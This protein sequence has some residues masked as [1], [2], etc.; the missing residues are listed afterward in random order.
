M[1]ES[2]YAPLCTKFP[3]VS[4]IGAGNVGRTVAQRIVERNLADAYL[5]D[6]VEG[7]PQ[8]IALDLTEAK[9]LE[10]HNRQIVGSNDYKDTANS[11]VIVITAGFPRKPGMSRDDLLKINGKIVTEVAQKCCEYSP[12]A[13]YIVIT[14]PLM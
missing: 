6:I 9:G 13:I 10:L 12:N 7:L 11:D 2:V 3:K 1:N 8:G 14:N 4:I 5:V